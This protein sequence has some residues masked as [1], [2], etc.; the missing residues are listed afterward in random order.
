MG[1]LRWIQ[2]EGSLY[3]FRAETATH[4]FIMVAPP[5][6]RPSLWVQPADVEWGNEPIDTKLCRTKRGA[7]RIA[8]R[9][10]NRPRARKL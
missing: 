6:T 10:A 7:E 9:F 3:T 8:Q 4:R 1:R 2:D 5:R